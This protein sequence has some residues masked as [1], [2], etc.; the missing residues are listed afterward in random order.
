VG[1]LWIIPRLGYGVGFD[2]SI[3]VS[4]RHCVVRRSHAG[5]GVAKTQ[6]LRLFGD[7]L[8]EVSLVLAPA[9]RLLPYLLA[10]FSSLCIM[11]LELV[12]SRLVVPH[13]GMSL[14][15]WTA[16]IGVILAGICL[17][18][19]LGGKLADR[20]EPRRVIGPLYLLGA[21]LVV[22]ILWINYVIGF[23]PGLNQI[24]LDPRTVLVVTLDFLIPATVL[25]MISPVVAKIAVEES[26]KSGTALGDVYMLGA[27]G[28]IVGTFIAGF[29][30][31]YLAPSSTIVCVVA[32]SLALL[33]AL[34]AGEKLGVITGLIASALLFAGAVVSMSGVTS[35]GGVALGWV[36]LN[37]VTLAGQAAAA[38][39]GLIGLSRLSKARAVEP[40]IDTFEATSAPEPKKK[41]KAGKAVAA[42]P[43]SLRD[44]AALAFV[45]S[46]AFMAFEMVAGRLVTRHL[47]SSVYGWTS[48]I[49][50]LLAGLSIGNYLGGK[51]AD[52]VTGPRPASWLFLISSVLVAFVII[53]ESPAGFVVKYLRAPIESLVQGREITPTATDHDAF[54]SS[55][56]TM[57]GR[58]WPV[59]FTYPWGVRILFWT[60]VVFLPSSI[61]LGTVSPLV[62]K[63]AVERMR[64]AKKPTGAAIGQ[65]YAW[66][67]VGSII[68]TFLTG[69]VLIDFLGTRGVLL[70]LATLMAIAATVLGS[71]WHAAWAGIPVGL[72]VIALGPTLLP[73]SVPGL[74]TARKF[75]TQQALKWGIR[76]RTSSEDD[77]DGSIVYADESN[78]YYIKVTNRDD[79]AT[80]SQKRTLVLDNLIHGYFILERPER[81]DYDYEHIYALVT[82][83]SVDAKI[84]AGVAEDAAS[85]TL[86][87]LFL[88]GGSYT[89]PRYLQSIY[90]NTVAEVAEIDPA[91]TRANHEALGLSKETTIR[92]TFGDARAFVT[93]NPSKKFDLVFGDAFND[94][95]VPWHLT[96]R[97]FNEKLAAMLTD[98]GIYMI[99]IIDV[100]KS[101][102]KAATEGLYDGE[103]ESVAA[104]VAREAGLPLDGATGITRDLLSELDEQTLGVDVSRLATMATAAVG[105]TS[106]QDNQAALAA[107]IEKA[108]SASPVAVRGGRE[109]MIKACLATL[110]SERAALFVEL[111]DNRR[112][113]IQRDM[114]S[115]GIDEQAITALQAMLDEA[116]GQAL[117][118][119]T[120]PE[121][122]EA[123]LQV[124]EE[125]KSKPELRSAGEVLS[126]LAADVKKE[127]TRQ[128]GELTRDQ[129]IAEAVAR[130]EEEY[131]G[132]VREHARL[133]AK[134]IAE[135]RK[136]G[137]FL[138]S[139]VETAKSTFK[140][141]YVFGTNDR[142]GNGQRETFVVVAAQKP[143]DLADLGSRE[144][145]PAFP[146]G[147]SGN[148]KPEPY[149][150]T[151]MKALTIRS[152][153]IRLSDDYAPVENLLAPVA[154][155]RG[156]D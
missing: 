114:A 1:E 90:P 88:G 123:I 127:E 70:L 65:V 31:I 150:E 75:L 51:V 148:F 26:K 38:V 136:Y 126:R 135:A 102:R 100:Y 146:R 74:D 30:L 103:V 137:G 41:G 18:N 104:V 108:L 96:T 109:A 8:L 86:S 69:F 128:A 46:L 2:R 50:V 44:L 144:G 85:A 10:F 83:R 20:A 78:Y 121:R 23:I 67:M 56:I 134:A 40:A 68:G 151:A 5:P 89:F 118:A 149:D 59:E 28:S 130:G 154:A 60:A 97:N 58:T 57:R 138:S 141:I 145:D 156:E 42:G 140:H 101:D 27:V 37:S 64:A 153:G 13:V 111:I 152:R 81:L 16:V 142:P 32:A 11:I 72:C 48:V 93:Q 66:G 14:P 94:F 106:H 84:R 76:E 6:S 77:P 21:A 55:A 79:P 119:E 19:V 39:A 12:A 91:V 34:L 80:S 61:A 49:G 3:S 98:E 54:L 113:V 29:Y 131:N 92:T 87:T 147:R 52:R 47:G 155:T 33:G 17:G 105:E 36:H 95:S 110:E 71:I 25:G 4:I 117:G 53:T 63:L 143:L 112:R 7:R 73:A 125:S 24:P 22:A 116:R 43:V 82:R 107:A 62:A 132:Q 99:N 9:A 120:A 124:I 35:T 115:L 133:A 45:A 15:V 139:W 122:A 129:R